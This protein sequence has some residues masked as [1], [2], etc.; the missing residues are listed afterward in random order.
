[1]FVEK[2][3][4]WMATVALGGVA[5]PHI[6]TRTLFVTALSVVVTVVDVKV[7][8]LRFSLTSTPFVL[9]GLP[10]GIFLGFRNNTAYDRF[11]DG[12]PPARR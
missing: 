11:W 1:M 7:P 2:R 4:S 9:L 10:L 12:R 6:W 5:L 3:A 8:S